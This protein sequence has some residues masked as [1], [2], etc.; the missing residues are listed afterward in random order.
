MNATANA[1]QF[2]PAT[3]E[4]AKLRA[5]LF[6]PS[7]SGKTFSA[8]RI[9]NGL[10]GR[11]AVIDTERGSASKYADRFAFDT[12]ELEDKTIPTYE[13][14]IQAAARAGYQI[15]IVDSLSHAWQ[16]LLQ[17]ID[18]LASA[19][20]RGNTWSAWSEG[21]PKQ[22]RL[23][24]AILGFPG[25][26]LATMRSK[27]EWAQE[28]TTAGKV[29]PVRVG[30]AP[31]Q[32]KGV[33]YEFDLLLELSQDHIA[34]IIKDRTGRF[35]DQLLDKP[36]EQ[37]GQALAAWLSDTP[38]QEPKLSLVGAEAAPADPHTPTA[39][40]SGHAPQVD[41]TDRPRGE[42]GASNPESTVPEAGAMETISE[43]QHRRIEARINELHLDR[44]RVK[45]WCKAKWGVE[46]LPG[47]SPA[48]YQEL[49]ARL[50]DFAERV[51]IEQEGDA[52]G[53][54]G[55]S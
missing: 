3:K 1:F 23:V 33:E 19:K 21:T 36:D 28:S 49:N 17:E 46:H 52:Q 11:I 54:P 7:G 40:P 32:G 53:A 8:L 10:G 29:K 55:Q 15:L 44:E 4:A 6:G 34:N 24:E 39:G 37:F 51:A 18:R 26:L 22:R 13:A 48:Q 12:L 30:L 50:E 31:E 35:Q 45:R 16:E 14:A 20:Y 38:A 2:R 47:L 5:A 9:A 25:H 27:T 43:D 41:P 42:R